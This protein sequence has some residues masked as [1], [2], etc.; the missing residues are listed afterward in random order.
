MKTIS[1]TG[2]RY[3]HHSSSHFMVDNLQ[4]GKLAF[5]QGKYEQAVHYF[6]ISIE[7][8]RGKRQHQRLNWTVAAYMRLGMTK[9]ALNEAQ[10]IIKDWPRSS[11]GYLWLCQLHVSQRNYE[12][13][14]SVAMQAFTQVS[15]KDHL[16]TDLQ[17]MASVIRER[18]RD[19]IDILPTE[20]LRM[21]FKS[22][23]FETL[24]TCMDVCH[25]WKEFLVDAPD[26]FQFNVSR[27]VQFLSS[28]YTRQIQYLLAGGRA[29]REMLIL[30]DQDDNPQTELLMR[31][32]TKNKYQKTKKLGE[33]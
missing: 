13:A 25:Q 19:F 30:L 4:R 7:R 8:Y 28:D 6:S 33:F 14:S 31:V 27:H 20:V 26:L 24:I 29:L 21:I 1:N 17:H 2:F 3:P 18:R 23:S 32:L 10:K 16:F 12:A 9:H 11:A 22:L 5:R 15:P